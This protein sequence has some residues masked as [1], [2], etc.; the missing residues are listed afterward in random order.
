MLRFL[1]GGVVKL[2]AQ[3]GNVVFHREA[4]GALVVFPLEVD[5]RIQVAFIV[6]CYVVVLFDGVEQVIGVALSYVLDVKIVEYKGENDC[7]PLVA[8]QSR[9]DGAL[10]VVVLAEALFQERS[11]RSALDRL[12][13]WGRP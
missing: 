1:G 13:D 11:S 8:P 10:V 2:G 9:G 4:I 3:L 6:Y 7:P 5:P 12:P